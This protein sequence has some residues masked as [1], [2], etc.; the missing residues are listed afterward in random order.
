MSYGKF[1]EMEQQERKRMA[2]KRPRP[3]TMPDPEDRYTMR[4]CRECSG[5]WGFPHGSIVA[6]ACPGCGSG[7]L[8]GDPEEIAWAS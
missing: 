1:R 6:V 2:A 5:L 7:W 8:Y 3:G 4:K